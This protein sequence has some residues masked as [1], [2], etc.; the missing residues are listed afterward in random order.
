LDFPCIV[1]ASELGAETGSSQ[2][3]DC[4]PLL[5]HSL[6][7]PEICVRVHEHKSIKLSQV[8]CN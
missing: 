8:N 4:S 6:G 3:A 2:T 5:Y 1:N 7:Q